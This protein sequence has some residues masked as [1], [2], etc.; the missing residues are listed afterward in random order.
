MCLPCAAVSGICACS[1]S[2]LLVRVRVQEAHRYDRAPPDHF[3][4]WVKATSNYIGE[5]P[6]ELNVYNNH[7]YHVVERNDA[8]GPCVLCRKSLS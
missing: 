6:Q 7:V 8:T 4:G 5:S 2:E 1:I 3:T